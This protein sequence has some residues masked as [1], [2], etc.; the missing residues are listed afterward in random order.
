[1]ALNFIPV[2]MSRNYIP[3]IQIK[4]YT[5]NNPS[6]PSTSDFHLTPGTTHSFILT[7]TNPLYDPIQVTLS[8][9]ST[10]PGSLPHSTTILRPEFTVGANADIWNDDEETITFNDKSKR[11]SKFGIYEARRN[12][13]GIFMEVV[14]AIPTGEQGEIVVEI[15]VFVKVVYLTEDVEKE[16]TLTLVSRGMEEKGKGKVEKEIGY[17]AVVRVGSIVV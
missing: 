2:L 7:I 11:R 16:D 10:A 13:I 5:P 9:P 3:V 4:P 1:M 6:S 8:T 12:M 17:W 15:P 14:P